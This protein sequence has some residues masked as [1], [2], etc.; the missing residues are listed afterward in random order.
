MTPSLGG[1]G[2]ARSFI[3]CEAK[4]QNWAGLRF[5]SV[6]PLGCVCP[7]SLSPRTS[8]VGWGDTPS[9]QPS[10]DVASRT[11]GLWFFPWRAAGVLPLL[12]ATCTVINSAFLTS[13]SLCVEAPEPQVRR[14]VSASSCS[15]V[16]ENQNIQTS[17]WRNERKWRL[18]CQVPVWVC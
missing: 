4:K 3:H 16:E 10:R 15:V 8:A 7:S 6:C 11:H 9:L 13:A 14:R 2:G 17:P 5:L 12:D 18:G 1:G